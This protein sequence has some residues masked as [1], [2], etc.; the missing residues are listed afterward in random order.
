[1]TPRGHKGLFSALTG[2]KQ[3]TLDSW[4][5]RLDSL[6]TVKHE[7]ELT[8]AQ[9]GEKILP[10]LRKA[11]ENQISARELAPII[12]VGHATISRWMQLLNN[13]VGNEQAQV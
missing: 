13:G 4:M 6:I 3:E 11:K 7:A 12:G 8:Q 5:Q 10:L 2:I 9:L 1:M